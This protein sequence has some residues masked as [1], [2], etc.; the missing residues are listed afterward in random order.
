MVIDVSDM[1]R[2][3]VDESA[4]VA[5]VQTGATQGAVVKALGKRGY[6]IPSGGEGT[7]ASVASPWAAGSAC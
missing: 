3:H 5:A 1:N 6:T 2:I 7:P 4:G